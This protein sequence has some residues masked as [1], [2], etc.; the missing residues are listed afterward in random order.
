MKL[1][2]ETRGDSPAPTASSLKGDSSGNCRAKAHE[3]FQAAMKKP[4]GE[5]R[6]LLE[7]SAAAWSMRADQLRRGE[8]RCCD[9]AREGQRP[10]RRTPER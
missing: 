1:K 2:A 3:F 4:P 10:D 6:A 7:R 9:E 5:E 8:T